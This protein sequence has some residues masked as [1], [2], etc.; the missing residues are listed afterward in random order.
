[1][2]NDPYRSKDWTLGITVRWFL[3]K[4]RE[5]TVTC[6]KCNGKGQYSS[7][8]YLG[9]DEENDLKCKTCWGRGRVPNPTLEPEPEVPEVF[10][11]YMEGYYKKFFETIDKLGQKFKS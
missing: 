10:R 11:N 6:D 8:G 3:K 2:K 1:V 5:A 4:D 9:F 7:F